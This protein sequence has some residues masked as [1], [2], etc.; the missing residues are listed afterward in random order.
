MILPLSAL[1]FQ[2]QFLLVGP[3]VPSFRR[4]D[5]VEVGFANKVLVFNSVQIIL[6]LEFFEKSDERRHARAYSC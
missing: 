1:V 3:V 5:I 4:R 6:S 2:I